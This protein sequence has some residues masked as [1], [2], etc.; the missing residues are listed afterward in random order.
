MA[1]P[2][3]NP[4]V[5]H[6]AYPLRHVTPVQI[7]FADI[8]IFGHVNNNAYMSYLDLGKAHYLTEVLP[9]GRDLTGLESVIVGI[10]I[11]FVGQ[12]FFHDH[13]QV[14]TAVTRI[15]QKSF[16]M[17][18]RVICPE[19]ADVRCIATTTLVAFDK[20]TARAT[21]VNPRWIEALELYE[22]RKL[23]D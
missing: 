14:V 6:P 2:G 23:T 10:K 13:V 22:G 1:L 19:T 4:R 11:D 15:S 9:M 5:P 8:D 20:A 18:Q 16:T 17:E 12:T 7:R 21:E 3:S